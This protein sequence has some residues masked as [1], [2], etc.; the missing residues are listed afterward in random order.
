MA[1]R[2]HK[3]HK[4]SWTYLAAYG[5]TFSTTKK[6]GSKEFKLTCLFELIWHIHLPVSLASR[7]PL[8][9]TLIHL[10]APRVQFGLA[11]FHWVSL[12]EWLSSDWGDLILKAQNVKSIFI[13]FTQ[14]RGRYYTESSHFT[15]SSYKAGEEDNEKQSNQETRGVVK[16]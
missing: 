1:R 10:S 11:L 15:Y 13:S 2:L 4:Q 6:S 5:V 12:Y 9:S 14:S 7:P 16:C 3:C 8:H